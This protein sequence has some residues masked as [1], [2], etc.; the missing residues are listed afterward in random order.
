[1]EL[2]RPE[3]LNADHPMLYRALFGDVHPIPSKIDLLQVVLPHVGCRT[4][5]KNASELESLE[6]KSRTTEDGV[7]LEI[8]K[9]VANL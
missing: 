2:P 6:L 5:P 9:R 1:M 3:T 8:L 7:P 4:S